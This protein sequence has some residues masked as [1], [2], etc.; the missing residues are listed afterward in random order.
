MKYGALRVLMVIFL[1]LVA[2]CNS[3]SLGVLGG[4][5]DPVTT[6]PYGDHTICPNTPESEWCND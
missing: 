1:I 4:A 2:A 5:D 6:A 3:P